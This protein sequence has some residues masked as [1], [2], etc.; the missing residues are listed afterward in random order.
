[1]ARLIRHPLNVEL[2]TAFRVLPSNL[3]LAAGR[4]ARTRA[5]VEGKN[6][7]LDDD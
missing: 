5:R 2:T 7:L 6:R 4:L 3:V 1:M